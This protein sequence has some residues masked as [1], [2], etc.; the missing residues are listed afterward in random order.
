[1]SY[2]KLTDTCAFTGC[3]NEATGKCVG[4]QKCILAGDSN[5]AFLN[6]CGKYF[7]TVHLH[8]GWG[9]FC[10]NGCIS[11]PQCPEHHTGISCV[12]L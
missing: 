3:Q 4:S 1:M 10:V 7:C 9:V 2:C 12:I 6:D 11:A 8:R 5:E